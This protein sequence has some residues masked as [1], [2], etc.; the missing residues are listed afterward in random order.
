MT[1]ACRSAL[2]CDIRFV[3]I[4]T[5]V[6]VG[7]LGAI[8]RARITGMKRVIAVLLF[9]ASLSAP[10]VGFAEEHHRYYDREYRD[11][12]EWS[13]H[14]NRAYRHWLMEE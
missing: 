13:E 3:L 14:E 5:V 1:E 10:V 7:H 8:H 9:S 2:N 12:H 4:Q 11:W 6:T